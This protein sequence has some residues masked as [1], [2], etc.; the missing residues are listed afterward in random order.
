MRPWIMTTFA[1]LALGLPALA[2]AQ[3]GDADG[4]PDVAD[5][6]PCDPAVV[7]V[8]Y[9]P[10]SDDHA[11]LVFE[12]QFPSSGDRDFNDAV[13]SYRYRLE[14]DANGDAVRLVAL[15]S[16][17]AMGGDTLLGL[18]LHLPVNASS[19]V[20]LTRTFEGQTAQP[21]SMQTDA[22][23]TAL[24]STDLRADLYPGVFGPVNVQGNPVQG[25]AM[26]VVFTFAPGTSLSIAGAPYDVFV[27][28]SQDHSH[29]IHLPQYS[30]TQA[31]N[32]ALFGT[33]NDA[34]QPGR[35]FVDD[36]GLPFALHLPTQVPY[37]A[38]GV[39]I[40]TLYTQ[41]SSASP[42]RAGP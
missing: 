36:T 31:M 19:V 5:A 35:A 23:A 11:M 13:I 7:A 2:G 1:G 27:V 33:A 20:S 40:A 24:L 18:G 16:A 21:L 29:E 3:D 37:P 39:S 34:S 32:T 17:P 12:D 30:G 25:L 42:P 22:E 14:L 26:Q 38:E 28:R 8:S 15:F 6:R 9:A 10:A 4:V 41:P